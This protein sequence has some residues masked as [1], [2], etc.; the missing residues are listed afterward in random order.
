MRAALQRISSVYLAAYVAVADATLWLAALPFEFY[1][2]TILAQHRAHA[3]FLL[4]ILAL[5]ALFVVLI[6]AAVAA[7]SELI[8]RGLARPVRVALPVFVRNRRSPRQA[9]GSFDTSR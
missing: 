6:L 3:P 4:L 9:R 5:N 1:C 7:T 8:R 2:R